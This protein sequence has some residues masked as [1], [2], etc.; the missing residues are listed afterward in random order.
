MSVLWGI[1]AKELRKGKYKSCPK[2]GI[3]VFISFFCVLLFFLH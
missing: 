3:L 2:Q 1:I